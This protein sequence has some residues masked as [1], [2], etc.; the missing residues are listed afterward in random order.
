MAG[1][2]EIT[3]LL[4]EEN[5]DV[6]A[7]TDCFDTAAEG[8]EPP[9]SPDCGP[10]ALHIAL[11]TGSCRSGRKGCDLDKGRLEIASMLIERGASVEGAADHLRIEDLAKFENFPHLWDKLRIGITV[12]E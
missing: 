8:H 4:L 12:A 3:R 1:S 6:N 2:A 7:R 5:V 11:V 10:T 9:P